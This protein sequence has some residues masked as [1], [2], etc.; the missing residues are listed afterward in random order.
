[1]KPSRQVTTFA[2][3]AL[4]LALVG[5]A[6]LVHVV[7]SI[8]P[9]AVVQDVL[10]LKSSKTLK[11]MSLGFRGLMADI[12]WTRAVQYFG[13]HHVSRSARFDLLAP[14]L[15]ITTDLDPKLIVAYEYGANFLAPKPPEG[16]GLPDEAVSIV[17]KG[18]RANPDNWHLY[19]ALGFLQYM[20][21]KDYAAA[22]DAFQRGSSVPN[23]HPWL[24]SLAGKM[25]QKAGDTQTARMMWTTMYDTSQ[26]KLIKETAGNHLIAVQVA[27]DVNG[28]EKIV[29]LYRI[30]TGH[31][32][33]SFRELAAANMLPGIPVD[34]YRQ[35]YVLTPAGHVLVR[36]PEDFK[37][38]EKGLPEGYVPPANAAN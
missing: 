17:E 23:A 37:F 27:E 22:A 35:P 12:Y 14:M 1:M 3:V 7:D 34:P 32:P 11:W 16:A 2:S 33:N 6:S 8:R 36:Y 30:Q 28:L 15:E 10:Y 20:E 19:Y 26:D 24:K 18:I 9:H 4:V 31:L 13:A 5:S 29:D 21:R 25:A 38:L